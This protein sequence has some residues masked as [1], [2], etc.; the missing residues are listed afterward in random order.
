MSDMKFHQTALQGAYTVEIEI[1]HLPNASRSPVRPIKP[2]PRLSRVILRG[3]L[4]I[5]IALTA[6][7]CAAHTRPAAVLVDEL[8]PCGLQGTSDG[9]LVGRS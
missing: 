4:F 8:D 1:R 7:V 6:E 5:W 9:E 3:L 2:T